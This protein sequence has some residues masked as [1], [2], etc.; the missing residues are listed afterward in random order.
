[1]STTHGQPNGLEPVVASIVVRASPSEAFSAFTDEL[2]SWWDPRLT[3]D[4][5]TYRGADVAGHVGG[6][7]QLLHDDAAYDIARVTSW[8]PGRQ[9]GLV[10]WLAL[11]PEHPTTVT[12]DFTPQDGG[13]LVTLAHGGW[14]ADN[15]HLRRKFGE[16]PLLLERFAT[17]ADG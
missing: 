3:P 17:H 2:G 11:D 13:T 7:V 9:L 10:F 12:V 15:G 8:E 4:A 5:T 1:M 14:N 16:W 6:A